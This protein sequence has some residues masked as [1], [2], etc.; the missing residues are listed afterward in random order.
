MGK[1]GQYDLRLADTFTLVSPDTETEIE[2]NTS[3]CE[4]TIQPGS[5]PT[6]LLRNACT[7]LLKIFSVSVGR[8]ANKMSATAVRSFAAMFRAILTGP[9]SSSQGIACGQHLGLE[10]WTT[11]GFLRAISSARSFATCLTTRAWFDLHIIILQTPTSC[12]ADVYKKL[13]SLRLLQATLETWQ[14]QSSS[15]S[16]DMAAASATAHP[17]NCVGGVAIADIVERLFRVLGTVV[18]QCPSDLS[19]AQNPADMRARVL[20]TCAHSGTVAEEI[21]ALL[22][23]LHA[24]HTWN[25][26]IN[27]YCA[28]KLYMAAEMMGEMV[29]KCGGGDDADVAS[30]LAVLT[31]IGGC[32]PRP[33]VGLTI[34]HEN[35]SSTV[36]NFTSKG[37]A[38]LSVHNSSEVK[39]LPVLTLRDAVEAFGTAA[40]MFSIARLPFNEMLLNSW[41]ILLTGPGQWMTNVPVS[42]QGGVDGPSRIDAAL[43]RAQQI[44]LGALNATSVLFRQQITLRRILRQRSGATTAA[45]LLSR[46]ASSSEE[47]ISEHDNGLVDELLSAAAHQTH[48]HYDHSAGAG[49]S[50]L[51]SPGMG[52]LIETILTRATQ[53][54]PLKALYSYAELSMAALNLTQHLASTVHNERSPA[55]GES[56]GGRVVAPLPAQPTLVHGVPVYY[57]KQRKGA[58]AASSDV[59]SG[60]RKST[61]TSGATGSTATA[62]GLPSGTVALVMEMGFPQMAVELAIRRLALDAT[63]TNIAPT[64]EQIVQWMLEHPDACLTKEAAAEPAAIGGSRGA[65][66]LGA[67]RLN[68]YDADSD[69]DSA[70]SNY[71]QDGARGDASRSSATSSGGP[72]PYQRSGDFETADQYA[73]YVRG[74][75]CAGMLVKCCRDFE[76]IRRGDI[77]HVLRVDTEGLHDLNVQVD[78]QMHAATYWMRFVHVELLEPPASSSEPSAA[79]SADLAAAESAEIRIGSHVRIRPNV[80]IPCYKWGSVTH[81][82]IGVVTAIDDRDVTVDFPQQFS[83][84]GQLSEMELVCQANPEALAQQQQLQQQQLSAGGAA[85]RGPQAMHAQSADGV[86]ELIEDWSRCI[87]SLTVSSNETTARH[88]LDTTTSCWQ[89]SNRA[90]I[91]PPLFGHCN[92]AAVG[93]HWIR[94]QIHENVLIHSLAI[95]VSPQDG[96]HQPALVVVR[97][98]DS[99]ETTKDFGWVSVKPTDSHVQLLSDMRQYHRCVEIVVKQCRNN[100]IH[101]RVQGV[102]IAGRRRQTDVELMLMNASFLSTEFDY[103][104]ETSGG[105]AYAM[106]LASATS[107]PAAGSSTATGSVTSYA[108]YADVDSSTAS[109]SGAGGNGSTGNDCKVLVWGL[110]DKEQL[111]GLKG[112]KIK[113]PTLSATL[114]QLRPVHLSGGSKSLFVVSQDGKVYA[115]GEGTNGRLGLGHNYNVSEPRMLSVLSQYVVKKVAVHSGGKHAMALTLDGKVFSWGEGEDGKLGHGT[116]IT[117]DKPKLIEAL[118][119]KRIRDIACGSSHSA[120]ITSAGELYTWGLG[121]YGRLGHG[122][123]ATQLKPRLVSALL[124]YRVVQVACGSRD[125]QTLALTEEGFVFSW[126]DGDFGKLGRGGSEGCSVPHQVERLNGIGVVQIECGAQFSLALSKAGEVWTWGKGDYYRLGHGSDQH[127]R[128]PTPIH[129]LRGKRVIH[130]AVGALHCL[131]VTETGQVFAWGDN[132][133]GQQGSGT[134]VVNKKPVSVVGLDNVFVNRVACGSSHSVAW[135]LPQSAAEGDKK[136]PVPFALPKDPLGGSSLGFYDAELK[137]TA[138]AAAAAVAAALAQAGGGAAT[139]KAVKAT[140]S[141]VLLSLE[142]RAARQMALNFVLNAMSIVQARQCIVAAL[143]SHSQLA[144]TF[145]KIS[146]SEHYFKELEELHSPQHSGGGGGAAG[147][148]GTAA[149]GSSGTGGNAAAS[150]AHRHLDRGDVIAQGGGEALADVSALIVQDQ[151]STPD[152][153]CP[154]AAMPIVTASAIHAAQFQSLTGSTSLS[155]SVSSVNARQSKMS[156]SAMSVM[157]ATMTHQ[158]EVINDTDVIGLDEFTALLGESEAK[159]LVELLKLSVAGRTGGPAT[160]QTIASTLIALGIHSAV[161][162][163][164]LLET[165]ITELEDLCTSRHFLGKLPKPVVQETSHPYIDDITLVGK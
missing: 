97:V 11:L 123:N 83:W 28:Q 38:M 125:A 66:A 146:D 152:S 104:R 65:T 43:L 105:G 117:L 27:A 10:T 112:S 69:S 68:D 20:L 118:R 138:G 96:S 139:G 34:V 77:G 102:Q 114:S 165:C 49:S 37:K 120:A 73:M 44:H 86:G 72:S 74:L 122:D 50:S 51:A 57:E 151:P 109:G 98:G 40:S 82:S 29:A 144:S 153:D 32:D 67:A 22:R 107:L 13:Q 95:V 60:G 130:V 7:K 62:N 145:E 127:V 140:L 70:A 133:H 156:V 149:A 30:V 58:G 2:E 78:W 115:C 126:G 48:K 92:P 141:D 142:S 31:L 53:T 121:E 147:A 42:L 61:L 41:S 75:V 148:A 101:C 39:K 21:V 164:M 71:A 128:K 113:I 131:A 129:G 26:T 63:L 157:A 106:P 116:R 136:E 154:P 110:N 24:T 160:T 108:S 87:H 137:V 79:A 161:I 47:S 155:T 90:S 163:G 25:G 158:D 162:G 159:S 55:H 45:G 23:K 134:T 91:L 6:K 54:N 14:Q 17:N 4:S 46:L 36:T 135:S 35:Q 88:L 8:H 132:D 89:S 124:D 16:D 56:A 150:G 59:A 19:L 80:T 9:K 12:E 76:E 111:G 15:S 99:I 143:T 1:E 103:L 100:G 33:R 64:V 93:R 119:S 5:H 85:A 3:M 84:T 52:T 81:G 94:L 18:M